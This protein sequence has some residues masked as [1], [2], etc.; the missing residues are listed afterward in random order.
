[1]KRQKVFISYAYEDA[2]FVP[3]AARLLEVHGLHPWYAQSHLRGGDLFAEKIGEELANSDVLVVI[4]SE[5]ARASKWITAEITKFTTVKP[6]APVIPVRLA[7]IDLDEISPG[8]SKHQAVD[9]TGDL[10][11]G[12]RD[13]L[14]ALGRDFLSRNELGN[15]R[16]SDDRREGNDRRRFSVDHRLSVGLLVAYTRH[17]GKSIADDSPL[18]PGDIVSLRAPVIAELERYDYHDQRTGH[19]VSATTVVERAFD[20]AR[21]LTESQGGLGS[22][23]ILGL[24]ARHVLETYDVTM[25]NRRT[26]K[27]RRGNPSA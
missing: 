24:L 4:I 26:A 16:S 18:C 7:R 21:K 15:R 23:A 9:F 1:M 10:L 27:R 12:F 14:A 22:V 8:L 5:S 20:H 11:A 2:Y 17:T 19:E 25:K 3:L 6:K 13:L